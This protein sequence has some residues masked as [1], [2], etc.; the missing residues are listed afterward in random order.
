VKWK[1]GAKHVG[2]TTPQRLST[3]ARHPDYADDFRR[4]RVMPMVAGRAFA[5]QTGA[6]NGGRAEPY[7]EIPRRSKGDG[8]LMHDRTIAKPP[9]IFALWLLL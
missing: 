2:G 9:I 5:R 1:Q 8:L 3:K 7:W 6:P 4:S